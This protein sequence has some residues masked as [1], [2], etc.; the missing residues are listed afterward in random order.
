MPSSVE[1]KAINKLIDTCKSNI[2]KKKYGN[3]LNLSTFV[4]YYYVE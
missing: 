1:I 2:F 4:T 3:Y